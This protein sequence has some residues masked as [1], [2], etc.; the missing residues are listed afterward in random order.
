MLSTFIRSYN[1]TDI[2]ACSV[3]N[4][5]FNGNYKCAYEMEEA[6]CTFSCPQVAGLKIEGRIDI[7]YKCSYQQGQYLP[8]PIPKCIFRKFQLFLY[9]YNKLL[10]YKDA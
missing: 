2:N 4:T 3:N 8:A 9:E 10:N 5:N 1:S 6:R 7:E